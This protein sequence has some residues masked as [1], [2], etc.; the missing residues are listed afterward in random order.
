MNSNSTKELSKNDQKNTV[1]SIG[2][3]MQPYTHRFDSKE[4]A[5][6]NIE[7]I[8]KNLD[9]V[10]VN[11]KGLNRVNCQEFK[12]YLT[13]GI[14]L[15]I[16]SWENSKRLRNYI[17]NYRTNILCF[18]LNDLSSIHPKQIERATKNIFDYCHFVQESYSSGEKLSEKKYHCYVL[19]TEEAVGYEILSYVMGKL[20]DDLGAKIGVTFD[21]SMTLSKNILPSGKPV[22]VNDNLEVYSLKPY[23][24]EISRVE[25]ILEKE[26]KKIN[27]QEVVY[28]LFDKDFNN[29]MI[30]SEVHF[31]N[32]LNAFESQE[33][34]ALN[35]RE[36]SYLLMVL[37][38]LDD[39]GQITFQQK[40]QL[41]EALKKRTAFKQDVEEFKNYK[42]VTVGT[43]VH[44]L[45]Q[46]GVATD[47]LFTFMENHEIRVDLS[48][49]IKGK[50]YE[51]KEVYEKLKEI[52]FGYTYRGMKIL[53]ISDTGTG[54]SFALTKMIHEYNEI[55]KCNLSP[56]Q[57]PYG[58]ALYN[59]PRNALINNL[60]NDFESDGISL[61]IT[62][63]DKYEA[64]ERES[65][66]KTIPS[67]LTTIDHAPV[68]VDMKMDK[69]LSTSI[70]GPLPLLLIT[71]ETHVLPTDSSYKPDVIRDYLVAERAILDAG[72]VSLHVTATPHH[73]RSDDYD[74][75]I[76]IHQK[77]HQNPF[78]EAK[79]TILDGTS[80][81][82]EE[83]VLNRIQLAVERDIEKKLLVF[84][85]STDTIEWYTEELK[86]RG[87]P[88]I[89]IFAKKEKKRSDEELMLIDY[90][91]IPDNIQVILAT[92]V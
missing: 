7:V 28:R 37:N 90:G 24:N 3:L 85:E 5:I 87:I 11:R 1:K 79:Y 19:V 32:L 63:S 89:G 62:G 36:I 82:V 45:K 15:A 49:E 71:D 31:T 91:L 16:G 14:P 17:Q 18:N 12:C 81:Q 35:Y 29:K 30:T 69:Q 25:K 41:A 83:K 86:K 51:N 88:S 40:I 77:D 38:N 65:M 48:F 54:K 84:I 56:H 43:L 39:D 78:K 2:I 72:G 57:H 4:E 44:I 59:C 34:A 68:I 53:L 22:M 66:V 13:G 6:A 23:L 27:N 60:Q 58:F 10:N 9:E 21:K 26:R 33:L 42:D 92:T 8:Q 80:E 20:R 50:I 70:N 52:L 67:F 75:I 64:K 55:M 76:K 74:L 61:R 47:D 46:Y 73:L